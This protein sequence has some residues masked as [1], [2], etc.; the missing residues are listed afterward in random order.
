[1]TDQQLERELVTLDY[2][3]T[4]AK[5]KALD[6]LLRREREKVLAGAG[7]LPKS[8]AREGDRVAILGTAHR[9]R[10]GI[11]FITT[12]AGEDYSVG[13]SVVLVKRP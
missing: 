10:G 7:P 3:G 1:M 12:D 6:E 5:R 11:P 8:E 9:T 4:A 13:R 2:H